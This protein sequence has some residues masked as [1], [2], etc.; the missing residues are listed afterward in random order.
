[1]QTPSHL[2][3]LETLLN[4]Y[5]HAVYDSTATSK[6]DIEALSCQ[7]TRFTKS[8]VFMDT[9]FY[10]LSHCE[11]NGDRA[12]LL[13]SLIKDKFKYDFESIP[14][15]RLKE[16]YNQL[17]QFA[18]KIFSTRMETVQRQICQSLAYLFINFTSLEPVT[19]D[20]FL[21]PFYN[22]DGE[23]LYNCYFHV[24]TEIAMELDNSKLVLD[25]FS[26]ENV[27]KQI[28]ER[29]A[30]I[31]TLLNEVADRFWQDPQIDKLQ[32]IYCFTA[33]VA[34]DESPAVLNSL[35]EHAM[36]PKLFSLLYELQDGPEC[37]LDCLERIIQ[38]TER[39]EDY[40]PII[41]YLGYNIVN[42][43]PFIEGLLAKHE[44]TDAEEY[45]NLVLSF[46]KRAVDYF[47]NFEAESIGFINKIAAFTRKNVRIF[48]GYCHFWEVYLEEMNRKVNFGATRV[49]IGIEVEDLMENINRA[50]CSQCRYTE[51]LV[52]CFDTQSESRVIKEHSDAEAIHKRRKK[53]KELFSI[54]A[55]ILTY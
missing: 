41:G 52:D 51:F 45:I 50:L 42:L 49:C 47:A 36:M 43:L 33:W 37:A 10:M 20:H 9:A 46:C 24:L 28:I 25:D 27:K 5:M 26:R 1:M 17:C 3:E 29:Q 22:G 12:V 54:L 48:E 16:Y 13:T 11:C 53:A 30:S 6:H 39:G 4:S 2:P 34:L 38:L 8:S 14:I 21:Q 32:L 44:D 31:L 40:A 15:E 7:L 19:I 18:F 55:K 23:P 35:P